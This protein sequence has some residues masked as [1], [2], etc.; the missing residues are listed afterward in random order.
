MFRILTN[1]FLADS[2]FLVV[3]RLFMA[4]C[5]I[6]ASILIARGLGPEKKG[7]LTTILTIPVLV[8]YLA[9]MGIRQSVAYFMGHKIHSDQIIISTVLLLSVIFSFIGVLIALIAYGVSGIIFSYG[10]F[11]VSIAII[12]LPISLFS[13]YF[14]GILLA[15]QE[16]RLLAFVQGFERAGYFLLT[17]GLFFVGMMSVE[18]MLLVSVFSPFVLM[19]FGFLIVSRYGELSPKYIPG[20]PIEFLKIGSIN[21]LAIFVIVLMYR[22][23][24]IMLERMKGAYFVGVYS[25]GVGV[26]EFLWL[27][28]RALTMVL[29]ARSSIAKDYFSFAKKTVM[30][31]K[32]TLWCSL[33]FMS[34]LFFL[35]PYLI[36]LVY[37]IEYNDSVAVLQA[38]IPGIWFSLVFKIL[39]AD[40]AGRGKPGTGMNIFISCLLLNVV[41]NFLWIPIYGAIGSAW[42]SSVSYAVLAVLFAIKYARINDISFVEM[43]VFSVNDLKSVI[44]IAK[45]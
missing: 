3:G 15:K 45:G 44:K 25:I 10:W 16:I 41:L 20:V 23:D 31:L 12:I 42:A 43:F 39:H 14:I 7:A 1:K 2:F 5:G 6:L 38:I 17:L 8:Q 29:F 24:I 33:L 4:L 18:S 40:M 19:M 30:L 9:D 28:P 32:F 26:A 27:V 21:A 37:G 36:P 35:T 13:S 34:I 11:S 22:I